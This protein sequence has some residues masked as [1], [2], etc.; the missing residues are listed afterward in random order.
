MDDINF[1]IYKENYERTLILG[2]PVNREKERNLENASLS[3]L[4]ERIIFF[5]GIY[6]SDNIFTGFSISFLMNL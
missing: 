5:S 2:G 1:M 6:F 4:S 3:S